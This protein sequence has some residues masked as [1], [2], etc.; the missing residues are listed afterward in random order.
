MLCLGIGFVALCYGLTCGDTC[1][2]RRAGQGRANGMVGMTSGRFKVSVKVAL[3]IAMTQH[4][5]QR[6][7]HCVFGYLEDAIHSSGEKEE[8]RE[9]MLMKHPY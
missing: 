8:G 7:C 2:P 1:V 4:G 5:G 6:K 9:K 3:F